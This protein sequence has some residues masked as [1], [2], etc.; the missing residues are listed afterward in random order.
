MTNELSALERDIE[1]TR[2]R[3]AATIDELVHRASPK[4]IARREMSSI[5][6]HFVD[7]DTGQ[8]HTGNILKAVGGVVGV[9]VVLY[10]LRRVTR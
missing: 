5:K 2:D 3:L 9:V 7:L 8:P 1:D 6:S 10:T 4:T